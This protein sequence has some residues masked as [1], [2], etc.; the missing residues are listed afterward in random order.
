VFSLPS[1]YNPVALP[2]ILLYLTT[3]PLYQKDV[4]TAVSPIILLNSKSNTPQPTIAYL[5]LDTISL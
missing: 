1:I 2:V 3:D 4:E 5:D